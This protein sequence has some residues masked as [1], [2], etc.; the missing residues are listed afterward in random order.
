V[1]AG[2]SPGAALASA[3]SVPAKAFHLN[4]RGRIANGYKA[5]LLMV[6]GDPAKDINA[7]RN[8]V[9]IWKD[10]RLVNDLRQQKL[11]AVSK[12]NKA[13]K[14]VL[15]LPADGRISLFS[16]EK[17]GSPFGAGWFP[18]NDERMGVNRASL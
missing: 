9:N 5:D 16:E 2:L 10:G 7:T 13:Q 14:A 12:E 15:P 1:N 8:I 6:E 4:D 3:T 18:S 11:L 17:L